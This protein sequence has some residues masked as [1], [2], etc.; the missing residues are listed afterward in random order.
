MTIGLQIVAGKVHGLA[1]DEILHGVRRYQTRIIAGCVS[2][3][4]T[5]AINQDLGI[6]SKNRALPLRRCSRAVQTVGDDVALSVIALLRF[7]GKLI[8]HAILSSKRKR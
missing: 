8:H 6:D 4:K 5:L 1:L 7:T 2:G 3:P